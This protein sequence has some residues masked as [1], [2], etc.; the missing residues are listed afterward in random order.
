[1]KQ[2]GTDRIRNVAVVGH[3]GTGKT[4]LVEALLFATKAIDRLGRVEDGTTTTDFDPEEIRRRITVNAALA[5]LEWRDHK[6][7]LIDTPGYPDFIGEVAGALRAAESALVV[8]DAVAGVEVQTEKVWSLAGR[9]RASR[10]AVVTRAD[11]ENASFARVRG[12]DHRRRRSGRDAGPRRLRPG[13][14]G[15]G[16]GRR[17]RCGAGG[18]GTPRGSRRGNQ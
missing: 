5:P 11:R 3:G 16:S 9:E 7:N 1:V 15:E 6:I 13:R 17:G 4:S 10:I 14:A 8:I 2:Y 18:A 12:G